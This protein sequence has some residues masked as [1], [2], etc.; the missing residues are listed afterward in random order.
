MIC[1]NCG[2]FIAP[3]EK[4]CKLCGTPTTP[5]A[6]KKS[7]PHRT[8]VPAAEEDEEDTEL[9]FMPGRSA[10]RVNRETERVEPE[11]ETAKERVE[12]EKETTGQ[13]RKRFLIL[14]IITLI[15]VAAVWAAVVLLACSNCGQ[16]KSTIMPLS[17][18]TDA[19]QATAEPIEVPTEAPTAEPTEA[20]T[21]EPTEA[22]VETPISEPTEAPT[23]TAAPTVTP[24]AKPRP[25]PTPEPTAAPK[26]KPPITIP[27]S[28]LP[29]LP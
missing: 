23:P 24:T 26:T 25:T 6:Q 11:K 22:P 14:M 9:Y 28:T 16:T 19:P 18:P 8:P 5:S 7:V 4:I 2:K 3:D 13:R 1:P 29:P 12:P 20:L 10:A 21:A 27:P 17:D 15:T